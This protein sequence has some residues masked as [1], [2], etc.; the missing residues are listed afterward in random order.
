MVYN[1]TFNNIS[2][3]SWWSDLLVEETG[4]PAEITDLPQVTDKLYHNVISSTPRLS[5]IRTHNVSCDRYW[6]HSSYKSNWKELTVYSSWVPEFNLVYWGSSWCSIL[7]FLRGIWWAIILS[8]SLRPLHCL[9]F[10][11]RLKIKLAVSQVSKIYNKITS[12]CQSGIFKYLFTRVMV[13]HLSGRK[14]PSD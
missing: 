14:T 8:L 9:S 12:D 3:I 5:G 1:A 2:L 10:D 7:S 13:S 4:V 11:L 6:L